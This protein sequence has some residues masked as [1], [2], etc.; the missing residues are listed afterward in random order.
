RG[1]IGAVLLAVIPGPGAG[2]A[3]VAGAAPP[4]VKATLR[5]GGEAGFARLRGVFESRN[6]GYRI[7][8]RLAANTLAPTDGPRVVFV[9]RGEG[10]ATVAGGDRRAEQPVRVGDVIVLRS[11]ERLEVEPGMDLLVFGVP[12]PLPDELPSIIRPD[13]D[14]RITD[15]P[16]GCATDPGAYR[17]LLLTWDPQRGPYVFHGLNCHRVRIDDSFTHYHPEEGGFDEM[18]LVQEA[19]AGATLLTSRATARLVR[20]L[21]ENDDGQRLRP[22]ELGDV[23][24]SHELHAGDLILL[25]RGLTHRGLGGAVVQVIAVPGFRPGAERP[26]DDAIRRLNQRLGAG[27]ATY[28]ERGDP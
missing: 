1:A 10:R 4:P 3:G 28:G 19:P 7:E 5:P 16:G 11:G 17:R 14:P 27:L 21:D 23:L 20:E 9:Q 18:Y 12:M 6:P 25:P 15:R 26:M 24:R 2:A 8:A 13:F 22:D